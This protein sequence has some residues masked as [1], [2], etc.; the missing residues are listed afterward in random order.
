MM[1]AIASLLCSTLPPSPPPT[2]K[3]SPRVAEMA[4][5]QTR[6]GMAEAFRYLRSTPLVTWALVYIALTYT[7]VAVAGALAPG[8]VREVLK[9]GER[10]VVIL[11]APAADGVIFG[12]ALLN[13][14]GAPFRRPRA[15]AAGVVVITNRLLR[16]GAAPAVP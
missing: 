10:N 8:F 16:L 5:A 14:I 4:V 7:L 2:D 1:F 13:I 11:V 12:L 15:I 6:Q 3:L 9:V